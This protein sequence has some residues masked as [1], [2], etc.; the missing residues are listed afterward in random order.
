MI[1]LHFESTH[2]FEKL[3]QSKNKE[4]TD[5]MV[6]GIEQAM[7]KNK[8]VAFLF[9]ITFTNGDHAYEITLSSHLWAEALQSCLDYYHAEGYSDEAI[10]C[11]KLLECAKVW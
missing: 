10:D 2:E 3:F 1:K 7:D 5:G 11:W 9:E 8:K 4:I 6:Q